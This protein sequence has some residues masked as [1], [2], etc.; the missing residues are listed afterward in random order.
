MPYIIFFL[1]KTTIFFVSGKAMWVVIDCH[2]KNW[3]AVLK[4]LESTGL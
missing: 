4:G 3:V 1:F 2:S